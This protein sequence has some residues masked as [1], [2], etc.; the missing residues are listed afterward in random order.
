MIK[1]NFDI[2]VE[3]ILAEAQASAQREGET[4]EQRAYR[5]NKGQ[6]T[7]DE[8]RNIMED[9][10]YIVNA[11]SKQQEREGIDFFVF[12]GKKDKAGK[13]IP[14]W[15]NLPENARAGKNSG[16]VETKG[17]KVINGNL[18]VELINEGYYRG[19][20][21]AQGN[22]ISFRQG[23]HLQFIRTHG[24]R[25]LMQKKLSQMIPSGKLFD[26]IQLIDGPN[27]SKYFPS[28][29]NPAEAIFPK[30][31]RRPSHQR[32]KMDAITRL[33]WAEVLQVAG[34]VLKF[35]L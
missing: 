5:Q 19:W 23:D 9:N 7:E 12:E 2:L 8:F 3:S 13:L 30:I 22:Y 35:D 4:V 24:L 1:T 17:N 29:Q 18:L 21:F 26:I 15:M 33:P 31:F 10:G 34:S 6:K 25:D 11:A 20:L 32:G 16:S 14:A 27:T 28:V